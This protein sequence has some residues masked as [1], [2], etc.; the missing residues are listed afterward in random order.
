MQRLLKYSVALCKG[1]LLFF[2]AGGGPESEDPM[3]C[4]KLPSSQELQA[5]G[6]CDRNHFGHAV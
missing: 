2:L 4:M 3:R 6:E 5:V 1:G